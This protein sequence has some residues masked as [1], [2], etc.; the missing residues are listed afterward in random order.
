MIRQKICLIN[1][2]AL[3]AGICH[4]QD[5][6][7]EFEYPVGY[8]QD[9]GY[10]TS[11]LN[12][13]NGDGIPEIVIRDVGGYPDI[14]KIVVFDSNYTEIL[15]YSRSGTSGDLVFKGFADMDGDGDREMLVGHYDPD[16]Y[17]HVV[18]VLGI[19]GL[20][21]LGTM[22]YD[23][24]FVVFDFDQ[25]GRME[26]AVREEPN[27]LQVWEMNPL[28]GVG[29]SD[30]SLPSATLSQNY[31]NPFNP[32]TVIKYQVQFPGNVQVDIVDLKGHVVRTLVNEVKPAGDHEVAWD[33]TDGQGRQQAS[34]S[35]MY[36]LRVGAFT[37]S[38]KL[39]MLK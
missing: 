21:V 5:F 6:H 34:G 29:R 27:T 39:L 30:D 35:Y 33:G 38:R 22:Y 20:E 31:P 28:T 25:D 11:D 32:Y 36:V 7:L 4:A 19:P 23:T 17:R 37:A 24:D 15:S 1:L 16:S 8:L 26:I 9:Q 10:R 2:I 3:L 18:D 12:D 14:G 13:L